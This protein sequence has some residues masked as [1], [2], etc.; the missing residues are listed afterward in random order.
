[1]GQR[2][3]GVA[4]AG[5]RH[6]RDAADL[7][8][9]PARGDAFEHGRHADRVPAE[10][11][12]HPDLGRRL[13]GRAGQADVDAL[14]E[15]HALGARRRHAGRS[16]SRGLQASVRSGKRGPSSSAF[17]PM[18]GLRPVRLMW[19]RMTISVPGP[20]LGSR[21]PAAFVR[22]T[23]RAPSRLEQQ[24][25]LDDQPGVVALV[26]VEAALEHDHGAAAETPEEQ[27]PGVARRR[28][29]RPAGQLGERDRDRVLEL[30]GE[31]A[32]AGAEDDPDLGHE[33]RPCA[34]R[35]RLSAARRA[36]CSIGGMG[37]TGRPAGR[38]RGVGRRG[39][40]ASSTHRSSTVGGPGASPAR[41]AVSTPGC[42]SRPV[43]RAT[44]ARRGETAAVAAM[45]RPKRPAAERRSL[46]VIS[47]PS[48]LSAP[49]GKTYGTRRPVD[50]STR[51]S[52]KSAPGPPGP[53]T[54]CP[55]AVD[56]LW[57][58]SSASR[59][60]ERAPVSRPSRTSRSWA[61]RRVAAERS[62]E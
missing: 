19:S 31:A 50:G 36:G 41:R 42:R 35:P 14:G 51:L 49:S 46:D 12:Q 7:E 62:S 3:A 33:I 22:T 15:R 29:G 11:G 1:M 25:R 5:V 60:P 59:R 34:G 8:A 24:H 23:I 48:V 61:D 32:E 4:G 26:Q 6:E 2:L 40:R 47:D 20:K 39:H 45:K 52:T 27:P 54:S 53:S 13:V 44:S 10:R 37:A 17:G 58:R 30:V 38:V 57:R 21:P 55:R 18:S 28:R 56:S 9:D 16:R 43:G